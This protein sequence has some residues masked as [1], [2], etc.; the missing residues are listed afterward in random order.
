MKRRMFTTCIAMVLSISVLGGCSKE[1]QAKDVSSDVN[2][3]KL[4]ETAAK[5]NE[6][7]EE[8]SAEKEAIRQKDRES[9]LYK[10]GFPEKKKKAEKH[11]TH[12]VLPGIDS[13]GKEIEAMVTVHEKLAD[14]FR[15]A[16]QEMKDQGYLMRVDQIFTY[17]WSSVVNKKHSAH[18]YGCAVDILPDQYKKTDIEKIKKIMENHGLN[19]ID[20]DKVQERSEYLHF[21][22]L[23]Q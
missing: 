7:T 2:S 1:K 23:N 14:N 10:N 20:A 17:N 3:V 16:F 8:S 22:Y 13:N 9:Y 4:H 21:S 11:L 12:V 18:S 5:K 19:F 15:G 6:Y